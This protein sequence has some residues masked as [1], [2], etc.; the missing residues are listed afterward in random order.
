MARIVLHGIAEERHGGPYS[1]DVGSVT[2]AVRALSFQVPGFQDTLKEGD[3]VVK[4]GDVALDHEGL[5]IAVGSDSKIH[6]M[7]AIAGAGNG[8]GKVIAGA[9]LI[10]LAWWNPMAWGAA[11]MSLGAVGGGLAMAGAAMMVTPTPETEPYEESEENT[12]SFHFNGPVNVNKQGVPVP[13]VYGRTF[14]GSVVVSA[15]VKA[16]DIPV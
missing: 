16:E 8:S 2:E 10:A 15:G 11:A 9:A 7:P 3:W 1:M 14:T 4:R 6:V 13:L 5:E 12:Q